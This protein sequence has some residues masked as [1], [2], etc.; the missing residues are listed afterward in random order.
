MI[1]SIE[2]K[3]FK[4]FWHLEVGLER[5]T[6]IV[7]PNGSGKTT[8][9]EGIHLLSQLS[10][11]RP[12][13]VFTGRFDVGD[14]TNRSAPGGFE[15]SAYNDDQG[16]RLSADDPPSSAGSRFK[17]EHRKTNSQFWT[18]VESQA[19]G[20][21]FVAPAALY[22]LDASAIAAPCYSKRP[23][24]TIET[25][26]RGLASLLAYSALNQPDEF[27]E[28]QQ[29]LRTVI[30]M[31]E[32]VRFDRVMTR[33]NETELL[34]VGDDTIDRHMSREQVCEVIVFDFESAPMLPAQLASEG[35]LLVL[36]LLTIMMV[37]VRPRLLLIE[38]LDHGLHPKAQRDLVRL[39]R[40]LLDE[41][42]EI[43]I[44]FTTHS[45]YLLDCLRPEE[46][47]LTSLND[48]GSASCA[49]LVDHPDFNRWKDEMR[50]GEMWSLFGEKWVGTQRV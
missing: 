50:P 27:R 32:R 19:T 44:V 9:L 48:D 47:R 28:I 13:A 26:G 37:H 5:L 20:E 40:A 14:L 33:I 1:K 16:V 15:L 4:G 22:N 18:P 12:E 45:P 25:D 35:T 46:V 10:E 39:L 43:Q 30:P 11:S 6:G 23:R 3:A 29:S 41:N 38:D 24:P 42:P 21:V 7:G 31:V 34:R 2:F 17:V 8:I 36:A 49:S